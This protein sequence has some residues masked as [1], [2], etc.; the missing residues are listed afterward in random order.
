MKK[1]IFTSLGISTLPMMAI[2]LISYGQATKAGLRFSN[3]IFATENSFSK[4]NVNTL[5]RN[6]VSSKAVRNFVRLYKNISGEKW[7]E[8]PDALIATFKLNDIDIELTMTKK[9]TGFI[10]CGPIMK[11]NCPRY[12]APC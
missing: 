11:I 1:I 12:K 8:I 5:H 4:T 6:D 10:R 2:S 3:N 9:E 7:Y